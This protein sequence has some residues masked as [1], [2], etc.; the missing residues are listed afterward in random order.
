MQKQYKLY[1]YFASSTLIYTFLRNNARIIHKYFKYCII[2]IHLGGEEMILNNLG[3]LMKENDISQSELSNKTG[4]A[5][6]TIVQMMNNESR[7]IRYESVNQICKLFNIHMN[8]LLIY[9]PYEIQIKDIIIEKSYTDVYELTFGSEFF[10]GNII[11]NPNTEVFY[12]DNKNKYI[13][14]TT[15]EA[16]IHLNINKEEFILTGLL[17]AIGFTHLDKRMRATENFYLKIDKN[18]YSDLKKNNITEEVIQLYLNTL[19]FKKIFIDR[20]SA[21]IDEYPSAG[22]K[23]DLSNIHADQIQLEVELHINDKRK[24]DSNIMKLL[25]SLS[26][27]EKKIVKEILDDENLGDN[28]D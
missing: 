24:L 1:S 3:V 22:N 27:E 7:N 23:I 20:V 5:R 8:E 17:D 9:S 19:E 25:S 15:Y 21:F 11:N 16:F 28:H 4:L 10:N 2:K 26:D 18:K 12:D 6:P 14:M 13:K